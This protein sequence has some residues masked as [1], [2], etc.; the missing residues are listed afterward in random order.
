ME[1]STEGK[2][3]RMNNFRIMSGLDPEHEQL[4]IDNSKLENVL[5]YRLVH[6]ANGS[7]ELLIRMKVTVNSSE[8]EKVTPVY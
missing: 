3:R 7:A 4:Y 8:T 5:E 6:D 2:K 1:K